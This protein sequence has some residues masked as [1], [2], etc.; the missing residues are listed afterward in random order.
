[1][2]AIADCY[3]LIARIYNFQGDYDQ[4]LQYCKQSLSIKELTKRSRLNVLETL[5]NVYWLKSDINH[6]LKYQLQAVEIAEELN[7]TDQL[8]RNIYILGYYY[9]IIGKDSQAIENLK[10]S[11][12]LSEKWGFTILMAQSLGFLTMTYARSKKSREIANQ[13][14]SRLSDLYDKTKVKGEVNIYV[15]YSFS[16]AYL[17][18]SS[19]RMRDH[20]EAQALFKEVVDYTSAR[21][22]G[23]ED[24]LIYASSNLCDLLLEE[25]SIYNDPAI[26]DEIM[27]ILTKN[28]KMAEK[29]R[30]Y[31]WLANTKLLQAKLA[32]IQ[33]KIEEAKRMMVQAQRI[34]ELHGLNTL[35]WLISGEHDKLLE[36]ID[37]WDKINKD[38]TP[39]A[40]RVRLASTKGVLERLQ[41]RRAIEPPEPV[42]E[43]SILL[44]IIAEG[45]VLIFS[46]T[47]SEEWKFDDELFGGFLTAFNSIS[48]EI[49]SE[50]L[51][52]VKFGKQ[53]VLMEQVA[54]FSICYLFKGQTYVARQKLTKFVEEMQKNTLLWQSLEQ[55]YKTSQVLELKDSPIIE[56][57]ITDIFL[58][59]KN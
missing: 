29:T 22:P 8:T 4:A 55:H 35:A 19:T 32:L 40:E 1:L 14:F 58:S 59:Q 38:Q 56:N 23:Q 42:D 27:P 34:A 15:L 53:T 33:M 39:I 2:V 3:S 57:L 20:V 52:R 48:D 31:L 51:D 7:I 30:N 25:L 43:Q 18:K 9:F 45:G 37:L 12:M 47:F 24:T 26:L 50:G 10:R 16:K 28:L 49:F 11:L 17:L 5:T 54:N 6:T 13:Y 36:Q 41:G 21:V 44:M 46:Y